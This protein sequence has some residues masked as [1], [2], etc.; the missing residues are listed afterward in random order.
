[1]IG[2]SPRLFLTGRVFLCIYLTRS[3]VDP[4][5][6]PHMLPKVKRMIKIGAYQIGW[7][8]ARRQDATDQTS[9]RRK[10]GRREG[11]HAL[12]PVSALP[13]AE[14]RPGTKSFFFNLE[15]PDC[16]PPPVSSTSP[17][18]RRNPPGSHAQPACR[19]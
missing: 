11:E 8:G 16:D 3:S 17:F 1:M 7:P 15:S 13:P 19:W 18:F 5:L 10:R 2:V 14:Q 9:R 12:Q 6:M 4:V